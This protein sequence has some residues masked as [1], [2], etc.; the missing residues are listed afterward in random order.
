MS[1]I[2]DVYEKNHGWAGAN[3][4]YNLALLWENPILFTSVWEDYSFDGIMESK[5]NLDYIHR[6]E[7]LHS[8]NS[9][10]VSDTEDNRFT[11]FHPG[12][13]KNALESKVEYIREDI[14]IAII[15]PNHIPAML[16]HAKDIQVK[17]VRTIADP[18]Q[19]IS[20]MNTDELQKLFSYCRIF[21][22]NQYEYDEVLEKMWQ[23][24][25]EFIKQFEA[26]IITY[27]E[28]GT[29]IFSQWEE[30]HIYAIDV[31]DVVDTTGAWDALRAWLLFALIEWHDI[32]TWVQ[33]GTL[34][35]SYCIV[36]PGSQYHHFTLDGLME[37]MKL[38]FWVKID[39]YKRRS[40]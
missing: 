8:A 38:W 1:L 17:S 33:L 23:S 9:V 25:D 6:D 12:A 4:A 14:G 19:Q 36:A 15:S 31:E 13:M 7:K 20:Q 24:H 16:E 35:A 21:I 29:K 2:S 32:K 10:I 3:I 26:V 30:E 11:F 27:D 40:Y 18:S 5:V 39:L 37:D 22:A 34:M 28:R